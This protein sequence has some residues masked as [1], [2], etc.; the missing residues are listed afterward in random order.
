MKSFASGNKIRVLGIISGCALMAVICAMGAGC[1]RI[2]YSAV[3]EAKYIKPTIA[4]VDF[5]NRAP[6]HTKWQLGDGMADQLIGRLIQTRRYVVLE[7]QKTLQAVLSEL[8]RSKD[9]RFRQEGKPQMGQ[10]KHVRY[11]IKGTITDFG[12]VETV[13]GFWR[14]FDWGLLGT[15]S[16]SIV[17]A[18]IYVIDVE[19]GQ[20]IACSNVEAK[21]RDKK[22]KEKVNVDGM[23][24]G[25][26]TFYQTSLGRATSKMLDRAVRRIAKT[27]AERPFQPKIASINNEQIIISGGKNRRIEPGDEYIV[28][29]MAQSVIDPDSG[30][31]L[32]HITG[33]KIGRVKVMQTTEKFSIASIVEG[34]QFAPGQTLFKADPEVAAKPSAVSSY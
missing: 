29:P 13:E 32:G 21:I 22:D 25:S 3:D 2:K 17:A 14:L 30:D 23:A 6:V 4:V 20:V 18:T 9:K 7:R 26:Y 1:N 34:D 10:L 12:H 15:S 16:H 31:L 24:F 11:L 5:E 8:K 19:S 28:R 33:E 27:I